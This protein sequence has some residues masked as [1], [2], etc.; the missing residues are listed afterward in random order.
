MRT[1]VADMAALLTRFAD[2]HIHFWAS[3]TVETVAFHP[4]GFD[5]HHIEH[6]A[7]GF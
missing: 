7:K 5:V 2:F 3:K 6:L 4:S 1:K